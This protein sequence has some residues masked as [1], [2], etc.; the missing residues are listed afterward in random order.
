MQVYVHALTGAS[1]PAFTTGGR[2]IDFIEVAGVHAAIERI[3]AAPVLSEAALREQHD[4]VI[5]IAGVV[6]AV[7]PARFGSFCEVE[8]LRRIL[9][10]RREVI[11]SALE[12]VR[13]REQM[14]V[15]FSGD[16]LAGRL[17][18][19]PAAPI[20]GAQY[21]RG[22]RDAV[23]SRLPPG[24]NLLRAAVVHAIVSERVEPAQGRMPAA[25]YHLIERGTA[26]NYRQTLARIQPRLEGA[27]A[28]SGPWP[29]FAFAPEWLS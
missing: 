8:E 26:G 9:E 12:L 21:L 15:R 16:P 22:R 20:S 5:R 14:T 28:V 6:D 19:A 10:L 25:V 1:A 3:D 11:R 27:M 24:L 29:P 4:V 7:L 2:R 17:T 18:P 23:A 13:G